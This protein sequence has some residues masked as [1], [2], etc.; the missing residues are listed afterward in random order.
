MTVVPF[1]ST[2]P[3]AVT[4]AL[5]DVALDEGSKT[6]LR[7]LASGDSDEAR[8]TALTSLMEHVSELDDGNT[9]DQSW[10]LIPALVAVAGTREGA[11]RAAVLVCAGHLQVGRLVDIEDD[12]EASVAHAAFAEA[13][14]ADALRLAGE[15]VSSAVVDVEV[16][17]PLMVVLAAFNG[18]VDLAIDLLNEGDAA[19]DEEFDGEDDDSDDD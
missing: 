18:H 19:L 8:A 2:T 11:E 15:A 13:A 4:A 10:R 14:C 12:D 3:A 1:P 7:V 5:T 17:R 9:A 16:L 6:L